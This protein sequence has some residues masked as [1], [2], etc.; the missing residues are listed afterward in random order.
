MAAHEGGD[1]QAEDRVHRISQQKPVTIHYLIGAKTLDERVFPILIDK[2]K[3]LDAVVD[4]NTT[5][6]L[7]GKQHTVLEDVTDMLDNLVPP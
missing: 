3:S 5:R 1:L 2:L 7:E 4:N 6:T